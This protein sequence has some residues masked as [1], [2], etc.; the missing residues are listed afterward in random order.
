MLKKP[1]LSKIKLSSSEEF[2]V[3]TWLLKPNF[4]IIE[5]PK[6]IISKSDSM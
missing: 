5:A 2:K 3:T 1:K 4:L 6:E